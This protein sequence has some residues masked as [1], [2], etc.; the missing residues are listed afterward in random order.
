M[1]FSQMDREGRLP[2]SCYYYRVGRGEAPFLLAPKITLKNL[3]KRRV[4][5]LVFKKTFRVGI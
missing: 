2:P 1:E 3:I 5:A 4:L